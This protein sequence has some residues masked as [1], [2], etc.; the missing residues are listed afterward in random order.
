MNNKIELKITLHTILV[1]ENYLGQINTIGPRACYDEAKRFSETLCYL[2]SEKFNTY[3]EKLPYFFRSIVHPQCNK[4][5]LHL[6]ISLQTLK[7][8]I[9]RRSFQAVKKSKT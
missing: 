1:M 3:F 6:S 7:Y 8:L 2:Y 9:P 5:E 4:D